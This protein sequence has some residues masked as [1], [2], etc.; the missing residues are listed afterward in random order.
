MIF[1]DKIIDAHAH[2]FPLKIAE[3]AVKS[4][5]DFYGIPMDCS[6]GTVQELIACGKKAGVNR[7]IVSSTATVKAQVRPINSFIY[8]SIKQNKELTGLITLH[9]DMTA[10]EVDSEIKFATDNGLKG[11]KLHPDFQKFCIDDKKMYGIT[12][13]RRAY[14]PYFSYG[15]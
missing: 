2:I 7:F 8:A 3:K 11:I 4:I 1:S 13:R 6:G 9:P 14:C 10:E 5:G 15:R 12:L